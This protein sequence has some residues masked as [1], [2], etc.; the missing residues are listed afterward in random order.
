MLF[1]DLLQYIEPAWLDRTDMAFTHMQ[2]YD[3]DCKDQKGCLVGELNDIINKLR[4]RIS[5][6][7][8]GGGSTWDGIVADLID[9]GFA[10]INA[11]M[12]PDDQDEYLGEHTM[13]EGAAS[14]WGVTPSGI[15][16]GRGRHTTYTYRPRFYPRA[17][18]LY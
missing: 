1:G 2:T 7:Q 11:L 5:S 4:Q 15:R 16:T 12:E 10:M 9:G 14:L 8:L 3:E 18:V 13:L 6:A 17:A